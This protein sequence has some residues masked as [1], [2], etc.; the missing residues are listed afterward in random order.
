M[1]G[2][3]PRSHAALAELC[4]AYWY[5]VYTLIRSRGCSADETADLTQD[6]FERLI[7]GRLLRVAELS[8]G[9]FRDLLRR[10]CGFFLADC[11]DRSRAPK[12]GGAVDQLSLD[13][14]NAELRYGVEPCDRLDPE[15]RFDR[16]WAL[17]VLTRA[18]DRLERQEDA[19]G[20]GANFSRLK[21]FLTDSERATPYATLARQIGTTVGAVKAAVGRLRARYRVAP[22]AEVA[23]TLDDPSDASVDEEIRELFIALGQ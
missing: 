14:A 5:P 2:S 8:K 4:R 16:A 9:R 23:A 11:R 3:S 21:P 7:E 22:R 15:R 18:L 20:R 12:R 1:K 17:D 13:I 19:A 10:D 6:F